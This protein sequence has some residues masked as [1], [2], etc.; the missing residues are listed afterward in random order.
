MTFSSLLKKKLEKKTEVKRSEPRELRRPILGVIKYKQCSNDCRALHLPPGKASLPKCHTLILEKKQ[1]SC[2]FTKSPL[3]STQVTSA[4]QGRQEV[5][6]QPDTAGKSVRL[7]IEHPWFTL[8]AK[9]LCGSGTSLF[10]VDS[11]PVTDLQGP[12][13]PRKRSICGRVW[14]E[15]GVC[16]P[17]TIFH[18]YIEWAKEFPCRDNHRHI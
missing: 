12:Q 8:K 13:T 3:S 6:H 14:L 11:D 4:L 9:A 5:Q 16:A 15:C 18:N 2:N 17:R 10:H 7:D 1:H